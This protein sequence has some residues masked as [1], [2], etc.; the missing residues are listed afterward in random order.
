MTKHIGR[1][2]EA[3]IAIEDTRG[4]G[5][6]PTYSL[7]KVDFSLYDKTMD[8]RDESSIG[9]IEDS[10]DKFVLEKYAQGQIGGV[11]GAN[12]ALYLLALAFG[13]TP[14]VSTVSDS[15]YPWTLALSN[16]NQHSSASLLIKDSNQTQLHKLVMINQLEITIEQDDLVRWSAEFVSKRAVTSTQSIPTYAEDYKFTKRKSK[17]YVASAVGS[18]S[19]ATRLALKSFKM[20][21]NKN[22]VRDSAIGT[23]EPVDIQNQQLGIEGEL[24]LNYDDQTY[25]NLMLNGT[26]RALRLSM[27]SEKLIG[28]TS[29]GDLTLDF[30]KCDFFGWEPDAPNDEIV[31]NT[32]N[33]KTNWD[34]TTATMLNAGTVRNARSAL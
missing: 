25:R 14:T 6:A 21:I 13:G 9:R 1:K 29:Y 16:T 17:I 27:E 34:L 10:M 15:R 31:S 12:S 3:A 19:A 18:L 7:G 8:G 30:A 33:F 20:T 32:I 26:Y 24:M 11:L 2:V 4:V 28:A 23:V 5:K 22:L